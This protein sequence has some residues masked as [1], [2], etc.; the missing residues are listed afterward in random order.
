[1]SKQ[2]EKENWSVRELK[3]QMKSALFQ[4]LASSKDKAGVLTL[5]QDGRTIAQ[6]EDVIRD[7]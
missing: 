1:M 4:R 2:C 7:P 6:P 3:W 5:A